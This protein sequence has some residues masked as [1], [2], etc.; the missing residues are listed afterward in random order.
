MIISSFFL[1]HMKTINL[2]FGDEI[3][4]ELQKYLKYKYYLFPT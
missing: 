3:L 1:F 4:H 2:P